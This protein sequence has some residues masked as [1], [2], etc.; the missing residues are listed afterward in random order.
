MKKKGMLCGLLLAAVLLTAF[1]VRALPASLPSVPETAREEYLDENGIPYLTEMD[2][3]F[4]L[5]FASEMAETGSPFYYSKRGEDPLI[6]QRSVRENGQGTPVL[7]SVLAY[8]LWRFLSLFAETSLVQTARWMGPVLGSLAAVPAFFYVKR[9][10]NLAG[11][12]TAG[13]LAGLSLPFVAH[14]HVGFFDTDMLLGVLPLGFVLLQLRAMQERKILRQAV[15]GACSGILLGLLSMTWYTFYT[16]FWLLVLGGALGVVLVMAGT[17]RCPLRRRLAVARGWVFSVLS[18]LAFVYLFRGR[19]GIDDLKNVI[20]TL[21]SVGD[22]VNVFPFAYQYTGEMQPISLLPAGQ[23]VLSV[24]S[25]DIGSGTGAM[26]GLIPCVLLL[27][28]LPLALAAALRRR[29]TQETEDRQDAL[30]AALTEAGI[31]FLWLAFGV[32][33]MRSRR[34]FTEIAVLPEAILAGL[35]VGF[36]VRLTKN[37]QAWIRIPVCAALMAGCCLPT[38]FGAAALARQALPDVTD[39]M[40]DAMICIR[41]TTPEDTAIVS[42]WDKG[43]FMQ[44]KARRRAITDGGTSNGAVY[45]YLGKALLGE[46][47]ARMAGIFRMLETSAVSPVDDLVRAGAGQAEAAEYLLRT[48]SLSREEARETEPP[49]PLT[50]EQLSGLLDKT[51]PEKKVPLLLVLSEDMLWKTD[52]ISYYGFWDVNTLSQTETTYC[53]PGIGSAALSPGKETAFSLKNSSLTVKVRM[54][55]IGLVQASVGRAGETFSPGRTVRWKDGTK[56]QDLRLSGDGPAVILAENEGRTSVLVCSQNL[57]DSMLI[58]LF[59]GRDRS[60]PGVT[61]LNTWESP[62]VQVWKIEE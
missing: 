41:E 10:T 50:E 2:S 53:I 15:C 18:A 35:A 29:E 27:A 59:F 55:P 58:R 40:N 30:I 8:G 47:P 3:Y 56:F 21:R 57:C 38:G 11:G 23:G 37:R 31:L 20:S 54:D 39:S 46:D 36:I 61:L 19:A 52:A 22:S 25:A 48:A 60:V 16:Y 49:V 28:A 24:F 42:W 51:H 32:V 26:G 33:L 34:R 12:V 1:F 6:G 14:T 5:R 43:Y 62:S 4:Y 17:G 45:Y 7:L 44:Y 9:R 13:L